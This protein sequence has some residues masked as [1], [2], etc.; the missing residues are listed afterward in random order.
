MRVLGMVRKDTWVLKTDFRADRTHP[1]WNA[2]RVSSGEMSGSLILTLV[3]FCREESVSA[4]LKSNF[5]LW[6][7][8]LIM[9][10]L[11]I[12]WLI[13]QLPQLHIGAAVL[14]WES[15]P[16]G[17]VPHSQ[18]EGGAFTGLCLL[19]P[20]P[21]PALL[22]S[23]SLTRRKYRRDH[24]PHC[25]LGVVF[26]TGGFF[27]TVTIMGRKAAQALFRI[28]SSVWVT[29]GFWLISAYLVCREGCF[30][31][32]FHYLAVLVILQSQLNYN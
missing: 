6:M 10:A 18:W 14:C 31:K 19:P 1:C 11:F 3:A 5:I 23:G 25:A 22:P 12:W 28:H 7:W 29:F 24:L 20:A 4:F 8:V 15:Q 16:R 32:Q 26:H 13:L 21:A 9:L 17:V 27:I 2:N 30:S